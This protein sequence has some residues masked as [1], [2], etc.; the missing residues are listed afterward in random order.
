MQMRPVLSF[1]IYLRHW[2]RDQKFSDF[3]KIVE[4]KMPQRSVW[5]NKNI[6]TILLSN[7]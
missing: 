6:F 5:H 1:L 4:S 3:L 2:E 7:I